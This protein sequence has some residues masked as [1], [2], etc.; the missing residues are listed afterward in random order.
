MGHAKR[1]NAELREQ[2]KALAEIVRLLVHNDK[3]AQDRITA[4]EAKS[5]PTA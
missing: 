5:E 3:I 4:L 2:V 1:S